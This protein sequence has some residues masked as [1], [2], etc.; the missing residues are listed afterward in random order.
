MRTT[1]EKGSWPALPLNREYTL[2]HEI[3]AAHYGEEDEDVP[4]KL[5]KVEVPSSQLGGGAVPRTLGI[6]VPPQPALGVMPRV[7]N[8]ALA[9]PPAGWLVLA[10]PQPWY[11]QHPAVSIPLAPLGMT[12]QPLFPIQ[13]VKP[14]LP[15]HSSSYP[16][17]SFPFPITFSLS[18]IKPTMPTFIP[19]EPVFLSSPVPLHQIQTPSHAPLVPIMLVPHPY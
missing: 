13:P 3:L 16:I 11:S 4:S 12:R 1:K 8:P 10:R 18:I 5:A 19:T 6:G 2:P 15:F 17:S 14:P 9:V 7:Y